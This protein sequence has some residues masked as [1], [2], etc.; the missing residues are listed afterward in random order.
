MRFFHPFLCALLLI[1]SSAAVAGVYQIE[2]ILFRQ[3]AEAI[4]ASLPAPDDWNAL[5]QTIDDSDRRA[6]LLDL[7]AEKLQ[8]A[9]FEILTHQAWQQSIEDSPAQVAITE[10]QVQQ[11]HYPIQGTL[12]LTQSRFIDTKARF[13]VNL[14]DEEGA[15]RQSQLLQQEARLRN[16]ELTYMD[17]PS[18]GLLIRI[19]QPHY[20]RSE[21]DAISDRED[22]FAPPSISD[23]A[24]IPADE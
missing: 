5:A 3:P 4:P 20:L 6:T 19:G 14:F 13:W 10:G 22:T 12:T 9:G 21:S 1:N 23:E 7:Q 17:H 2:L 16:G 18:L 8:A 15:V 24:T 11:S